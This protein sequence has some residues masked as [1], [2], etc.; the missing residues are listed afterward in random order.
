MVDIAKRLSSSPSSLI[1]PSGLLDSPLGDHNLFLSI[2]TSLIYFF[3]KAK[4]DPSNLRISRWYFLL[5][6]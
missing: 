1:M 5:I 3:D 2:R 4:L 6:E